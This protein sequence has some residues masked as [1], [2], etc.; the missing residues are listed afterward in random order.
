[1]PDGGTPEPIDAGDLFEV[2]EV[3][4]QAGGVPPECA[5]VTTGT[6]ANGADCPS[7]L[8]LSLAAGKLCTTAC[9]ADADCPNDRVCEL[10][11]SG[12]GSEGFC[13]PAKRGAP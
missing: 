1:M 11:N 6:C 4:V 9:A 13:V 10:R 2:C 5:V 3:A 8:C 12:A 7:G